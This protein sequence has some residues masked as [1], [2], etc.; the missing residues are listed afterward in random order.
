MEKRRILRKNSTVAENILWYYLRSRKLKGY[1][2]KRQ[3]SVNKYVLDFYCPKL[4]L[5]IEVDGNYHLNSKIVAYDKA[6]QTEVEQLGIKFL[7][8]TNPE[9]LSQIDD[10]L[11]SIEK[12][13]KAF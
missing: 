7:R 11:Q 9:I 1:K 2:F 4:K 6:R 8:F 10:V 13:F 3:F 12:N 5:A